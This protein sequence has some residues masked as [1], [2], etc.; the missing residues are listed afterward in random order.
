VFS[1]WEE[2]LFT[3]DTVKSSSGGRSLKFEASLVY[4]VSSGQPWLNGDRQTDRQT[5]THTHTHTHGRGREREKQKKKIRKER[6]IKEKK[7]RTKIPL[8][9]SDKSSKSV[10]LERVKGAWRDDSVVKSTGYSAKGIE[11]PE[12]NS[13]QPHSGSRPS[14]TGSDALFCIYRIFID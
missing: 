10:F 7:K 13:Q 11:L 14:V 5:H 4:R 8:L 1:K 6:K 12:F 2:V 9:Q 3:N